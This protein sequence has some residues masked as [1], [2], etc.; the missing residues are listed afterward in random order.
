M[1]VRFAGVTDEVVFWAASLVV[2]STR[3]VPL[4]G[5]LT[6]F[7]AGLLGATLGTAGLA[8]V[9]AGV[10]PT[11]VGRELRGERLTL[12]STS[13]EA[14]T[15]GVRTDP[16]AD[17]GV[18]LVLVMV[19][20]GGLRGA[21]V[22]RAVV[23]VLEATGGLLAVPDVGV[24]PTLVLT[25]AFTPV[26]AGTF[27]TSVLEATGFLGATLGAAVS[28]LF[29]LAGVSSV[30][31]SRFSSTGV[32]DSSLVSLADSSAG[33]TELA[34]EGSCSRVG[35]TTSRDSCCGSEASMGFSG[36]LSFGIR[37][38]WVGA[39]TSSS[40]MVTISNQRPED[41]E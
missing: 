27:F 8:V 34:S 15:A 32:K 3:R 25:G 14:G 33:N 4:T 7:V 37:I 19:G 30:G 29:G 10:L 16:V 40:D 38:S 31:V 6:S 2:V 5:T 9:L 12:G 24:T 17:L 41:L 1:E 11:V 21:T 36:T 28:R 20:I 39:D 35:S 18:A 26:V 13:V 22:L 23:V